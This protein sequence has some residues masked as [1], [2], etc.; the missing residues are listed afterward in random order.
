MITLHTKQ[1]PTVHS[2]ESIRAEIMESLWWQQEIRWLDLDSITIT[3]QQG[4][5]TL[6]GYLN[7]DSN[8]NLIERIAH[9]TP[10]VIGVDNQLILDRD[11][12]LRVAQAL[13]RDVRTKSF[14]FPVGTTHGW[15]RFGGEVPTREHQADVEEVTAEVPGVRGIVLLPKL[16][17]EIQ[18]F[19]RHAIQPQLKAR[20][21]DD[22]G[23]AGIA[24]QVVIQPRNRLV[25]HVVVSASEFTDYS[26]VS[27]EYV[28][29]ADAIEWVSQGGIFLKR[30][31]LPL[32]AFPVFEPADYPPAPLNWQPPYPYE[33]GSVRWSLREREEA[34]HR[35]DSSLSYRMQV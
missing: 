34:Q 28:V 16:P 11:L 32:N 14:I 31:E 10:G 17:G 24:T 29:P 6:S 21:Y 33:V 25:T 1:N 30:N 20:V 19:E 7:K 8:F 27:N 22:T 4:I 26:V 18:R 13:A 15:I 3:V 2:D 12:T 9:S 23:Y 5:V 35:S